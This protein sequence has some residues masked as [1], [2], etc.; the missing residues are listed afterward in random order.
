MDGS[1]LI[2]VITHF[3][4]QAKGVDGI[5]QSVIVKALSVV[6][7]HLVGSLNFYLTQGIF[8]SP[9]ND[10]RDLSHSPVWRTPQL[11]ALKKKSI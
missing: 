4:T 11:M 8:P 6:D 10:S 2:L 5:P 1:D 7:K 9:E 3:S